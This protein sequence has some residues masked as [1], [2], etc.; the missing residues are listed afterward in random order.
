[1]KGRVQGDVGGRRA[2]VGRHVAGGG[3]ERRGGGRAGALKRGSER[4]KGT[5]R[6]VMMFEEELT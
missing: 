6:N 2:A 1:M 5:V 3:G 4:R